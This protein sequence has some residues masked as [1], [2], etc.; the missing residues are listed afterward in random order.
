MNSAGPTSTFDTTWSRPEW[1]DPPEVR[2]T[3][4]WAST[5]RAPLLFASLFA[6]IGGA[7][8]LVAW[9]VANQLGGA[10]NGIDDANIFFVYA[11]HLVQGDGFVF[12]AGGERVE[13]FTSLLWTL[14]C[15]LVFKLAA[16]P[17]RAILFVNIAI[18]AGAIAYAVRSNLFRGQRSP[19]GWGI[20]FVVLTV[21][22]FGYVAWNT[23]TLMDNAAWGGLL[24]VATVLAVTSRPASAAVTYGL[25]AVCALLVMAR[26]EALA[27]VPAFG[28]VV[29]LR[30]VRDDRWTAIRRV[31]PM[32]A[33]AAAASAALIGFRLTYFGYPLPNTF[34]AKVSPSLA[35]NLKEGIGYFLGYFYSGPFVFLCVL[36]VPLSL[37]HSLIVKR[38][39]TDTILF[40]P[41]LAAVGLG[42]PVL[43]GGDHFGSFRFY[44]NVYPILVLTFVLFAREIV[45]EYLAFAPKGLSRRLAASAAAVV[46][47]SSVLVF[48]GRELS[49]FATT[50]GLRFQFTLTDNGR[51]DGAFLNDTFAG[52]ALP[53]IGI[54]A[55]GGIKY[56]YRGEAVDLMGLNDTR[57]AH[58]GGQRIGLKNHAAFEKSTFYEIEPQI[59]M[60]QILDRSEPIALTPRTLGNTVLTELFADARFR[61]DYTYAR[62]RRAGEEGTLTVGGW[63]RND[64]L[65]QLRDAGRFETAIK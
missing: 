5:L 3:V 30:S 22:D 14:L 36:C 61:A 23:V 8:A 21:S 37:L 62:V 47:A 9:L 32:M 34:Y 44:Q 46:L 24:L 45:P 16:Q 54:S 52:G 40:L 12:N 35:Y 17:E 2:G 50:S 60:P 25:P 53:S 33:V 6:V 49:G 18:V 63:Y 39:R 31:L 28:V 48:K 55:A 19:I 38:L 11:R 29:F 43:T 10:A 26:P 56:S 64:Y 1:S 65:R 41:M 13:G 7:V 15:A 58:N 57:M 20:L 51:R 4:S 59:V 42:L 27:W